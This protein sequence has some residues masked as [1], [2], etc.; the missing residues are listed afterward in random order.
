V[1]NTSLDLMTLFE[2]SKPTLAKFR[3]WKI[4]ILRILIKI[5]KMIRKAFR[6][7]RLTYSMIEFILKPFNAVFFV[8]VGDTVDKTIFGEPFTK[9]QKLIYMGK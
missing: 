7:S 2:S 9:I 5:L 6:N 4:R 1:L 3:K 8:A